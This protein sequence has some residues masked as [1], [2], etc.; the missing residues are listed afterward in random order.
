MKETNGLSQ[1]TIN[2]ITTNTSELV[3]L[4]LDTLK[5]DILRCFH[6]N[7]I[8]IHSINGLQNILE[9]QSA[10]SMANEHLSTENFQMKYFV[11]KFNF[12]VSTVYTFTLFFLSL[13][14]CV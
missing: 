1:Q 12:I 13:T 14:G 7:A 11:E 3:E 4:S 5:S 2:S 10:F 6:D 8:S 9:K